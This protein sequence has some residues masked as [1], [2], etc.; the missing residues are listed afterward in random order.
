MKWL[1]TLGP[2]LGFV[3]VQGM[4]LIYTELTSGV[5]AI[6]SHF[7]TNLP[8]FH[9]IVVFVCVKVLPVPHISPDER[10]LL[11]RIGPKEYR[12]YRCVLR[13]GYKDVPEADVDFEDRLVVNMGE[14]VKFEAKD[15]VA[16]P[17]DGLLIEKMTIVRPSDQP[18]LKLVP[19]LVSGTSQDEDNSNHVASSSQIDST[20][21]QPHR[22]H[23]SGRRKQVRFELPESPQLNEGVRDELIE[24]L[25]AKE[26]GVAYI[27]GHSYVK[28]SSNSS[29]IKKLAINV[30]F[31]FLRRNCR[32]PSAALGIPHTSL[33]EVGMLYHV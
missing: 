10:F 30:V 20:N 15:T 1:L 12:I 19:L 26:T 16:S 18:I 4:G 31:N 32:G 33:I 5:P 25:Q 21:G 23:G 2:S 7:V 29:F 28:A 22:A 24:I 17:D 6:F 9:Q 11:G 13:Y 8:A 3:R 14:F 27:L